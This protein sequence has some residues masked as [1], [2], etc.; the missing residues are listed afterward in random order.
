MDVSSVVIGGVVAAPLAVALIQFLKRFFPGA[1]ANAWLG[2]SMALGIG[3][4]VVA[5]LISN[6]SPAGLSGWAELVVLGLA[7]GLATSKSYDEAT[8]TE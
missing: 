3:A 5:W 7:F 2:L 6:G 8:K 1:P 4:Q